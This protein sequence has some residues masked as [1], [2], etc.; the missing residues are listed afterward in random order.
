MA[1]KDFV[2]RVAL[3]AE[4]PEASIFNMLVSCVEDVSK[5]DKLGISSPERYLALQKMAYAKT[6]DE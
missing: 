6:A 3:K 2:E 5:G 1:D 4:F